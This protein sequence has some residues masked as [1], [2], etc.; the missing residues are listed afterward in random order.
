MIA[1]LVLADQLLLRAADAL[2]AGARGH[3]E[4]GLTDRERQD[5]YEAAWEL[6]WQARQQL[7]TPLRRLAP[8]YRGDLLLDAAEER[9]G[10]A[11]LAAAAY[12]DGEA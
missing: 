10:L 3:V 4:S 11:D 8:T 9:W 5:A 6:L 2:A 7:A 1:H 12:P